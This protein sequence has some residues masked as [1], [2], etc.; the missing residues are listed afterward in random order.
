MIAESALIVGGLSWLFDTVRDATVGNTG[1][2]ICRAFG[3]AAWRELTVEPDS[4]RNHDIARGVRLAQLGALEQV[5]AGFGEA[6]ATRWEYAPD[7]TAERFLTAAG[8]FCRDERVRVERADWQPE[9][10][11]A[12]T[13]TAAIEGL[14]ADQPRFTPA[15]ARAA[16]FGAFAE[17]AVL[18]ELASAV[19]TAPRPLGFDAYFRDGAGKGHPRFLDLF[20]AGIAERIKDK[21]DT[22]FR[23]ALQT[24]WL[25]DLKA[26][27][28]ETTEA[29][30]RIEAQFGGL[31]AEL[32]AI[33][34][35]GARIETNT[36][37]ILRRLA[38]LEATFPQQIAATTAEYRLP[39]PAVD[40]LLAVAGL[41]VTDD[42][43]IPQTFDELAGRFAAMRD[44]LAA[45]RN[46]DPEIASL[47]RQAGAALNAGELDTAETLLASIEARQAA[48]NARRLGAAREAQA[49][50][51]A[52]LQDQ[53]DTSAQ[54]A[55]AALLRLDVA[56][57]EARYRDGIAALAEAPSET[58]WR[59]VLAAAGA[60]QEF[61][62]RAGRNDALLASL[63][64]YALALCEAPRDRVPLDW[65]ATQNNLGNALWTLGKREGGTARLE[66]AVAAYHA[67]LQERTRERVPLDWAAT[68][69]NLGNALGTLGERESGT[70]R[71][72]E[73]VAAFGAALQERTRERVP[74]DWAMTQN[75]LGTALGTLGARESGT[76]RLEEAVA[77]FGAALQERTR[78]RV[79]LDWATTQNN[80]GN[81]LGTL[82]EREDGTARLE[83]AVAA[84][85]ACL[86]VA[87]AA[88][89]PEW[90]Q[91]VRDQREEA[92]AEI[93][94][95]QSKT[96][97]KAWLRFPLLR[98]R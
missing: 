21:N 70:A 72:E 45:Q 42:A 11:P 69:N 3:R 33:R 62:D 96:P 26:L 50:L 25:A 91:R 86:T 71:L 6:N 74:L 75:N 34:A 4:P 23:D 88:W 14:L 7:P 51:L 2:D 31:Y 58:R 55:N 80:L 53:A 73:A 63:D 49:D 35:Q 65:A 82:G 90:V 19:E 24:G 40:R 89:P 76:A 93:A 57:A 30:A 83:E 43:Q 37:E 92:L 1:S 41:S 29:L 97:R 12:E 60:L 36:T 66:E 85:D 79:P 81:A 94:R 15:G 78:E 39:R 84:W 87:A 9:F 46:D 17:D 10:A 32:A 64:L 95:R 77:A 16:A 38:K 8:G 59:Y 54:R 5:L 98:R 22:R 13:L 56:A 27:G 44:A 48:L 52:G 20:G 18:E 28:F 67:A 61:G 47:K 68:Q